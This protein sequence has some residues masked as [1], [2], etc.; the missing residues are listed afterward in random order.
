M[1]RKPS[2]C[3]GPKQDPVHRAQAACDK[4]RANCYVEQA[5]IADKM[6]VEQA[7]T[8]HPGTA[9]Y[10]RAGSI[11]MNTPLAAIATPSTAAKTS[12]GRWNQGFVECGFIGVSLQEAPRAIQTFD[13]AQRPE[14]T[15][16]K[17]NL[18]ASR[19]LRNSL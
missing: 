12:N 5:D 18:N 11:S 10:Q 16:R 15:V 7:S 4:G 13:V 2:G 1:S 3:R 6:L 17:V 14:K 9:V 19:P 8:L